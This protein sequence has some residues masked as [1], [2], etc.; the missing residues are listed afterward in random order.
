MKAIYFDNEGHTINYSI[1]FSDKTIIFTSDQTL[2]IPVFRLTYALME[3][4]QVNTKFEISMDGENF[5][6]YVE[7]KSTRIALQTN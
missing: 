3:D 6:T 4:Q 7:G 1:T 5:K 2:N